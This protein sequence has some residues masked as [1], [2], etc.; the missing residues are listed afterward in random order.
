MQH[1]RLRLA[2]IARSDEDRP[3]LADTKLDWLRDLAHGATVR[4]LADRNHWS[5]RAMHRVLAAL[6]RRLGVDNRAQAVAWAGRHDLLDD[7]PG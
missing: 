3:V 1:G 5:H 4:D 6:Y 7:L 2:A